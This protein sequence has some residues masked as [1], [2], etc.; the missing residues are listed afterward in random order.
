M[1]TDSPVRPIGT[2]FDIESPAHIGSTDFMPKTHT[3]EVVAHVRCARFYGD[4][5]GILREELKCVD[6]R[7]KPLERDKDG[8]ILIP[9]EMIEL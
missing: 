4:T 6:I 5:E 3:Y 9:W 2:R 7:E 1:I 8:W